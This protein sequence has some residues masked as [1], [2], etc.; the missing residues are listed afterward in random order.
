MINMEFH[1]HPI[2]WR[3][4][5]H[6]VLKQTLLFSF[7]ELNAK[8][9]LVALQFGQGFKGYTF[10]LPGHGI[11]APFS[12]MIE[13]GPHCDHPDPRG[14]AAAIFPLVLPEPFASVFKESEKYSG[15]NGFRG[16][17]FCGT[18]ACLSIM[19]ESQP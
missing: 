10:F 17:I 7:L 8:L 11:K 9:N 18:K 15:Y 16:L 2:T 3:K 19:V 5:L 14:E 4:F 1:E 12:K 6:G 13:H